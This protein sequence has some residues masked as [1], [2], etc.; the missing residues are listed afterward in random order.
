MYSF[1]KQV[2]KTIQHAALVA[3]A[4]LMLNGCGDFLE[5]KPRD[6]VTEDN[7]WNEKTDVDQMVLGC[8][9][10][11][12]SDAFI[13]RCIVWG[14]LRSDNIYPG[15]GVENDEKDLY[16]ALRENLLSTNRYCDWSSFYYVINKCNT[17]ITMAPKVSAIDPSYNDSQLRAT[18]AEMTA[19]RS[20]CYFYLIRAFDEVPFYREGIQEEDQV[21]YLPASKFDY[22]LNEIINDLESVK[23]D[24][25]VHYAQGNNDGD[26]QKFN[27][28]VNRITRTAINAMLT[29][30]Y[31][32]QG[33]YEK[34][35][36]CADAV[37]AQKRA[38]YEEEYSRQTGQLS[39]SNSSVPKLTDPAPNG[40]TAPLYAND[41]NNPSASA[42]AIF[43]GNGNS[44]E[45]IFELSYNWTGS[46]KDYV[47]STALGRLYG[48]AIPKGNNGAGFLTVNPRII[49]EITGTSMTYFY[50]VNDVRYYNWFIPTDDNYGEGYIRKGVAYTFNA[51]SGSSNKKIP[52]SSGFS[53]LGEQHRNWIFYR[54]TDVMLLEAEAYVM[55]TTDEGVA[56]GDADMLEDMK[57]AFDLVYTVCKRS[58]LSDFRLSSSSA[59]ATTR[60][61]LVDLIRKERN[62]ELMFEG[63]RWFDLVRQARRDGKP[64]FVRSA[65]PSKITGS[66]SSL[67][68]PSMD[69]LYWP[70]YKEELKKNDNLTQK[71]I[72]A[73]EAE[74]SF[75]SH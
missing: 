34:A 33:N 21:A 6:I 32:W 59:D 65:V 63:K 5:I 64:D 44:F 60:G 39:S 26:C 56:A 68:F 54:M 69:A 18:I 38:D 30:M 71:A 13:S 75:K 46:T 50:N 22:V 8:Y 36:A 24:A 61:L 1:M 2:Y 52:F 74:E 25:Y 55:K 3:C 17:V 11:M 29:D 19:L 47:E 20:L 45:S 10:A 43:G 67:A 7:F 53:V 40:L 37:M 4:G 31:L 28:N 49:N 16:E 42:N 66:G 51:S 70:Y 12:Q 14:E 57:Q 35:I 27:T 58:V 48:N 62:R 73:N 41:I 15:A 23:G 9:T 72:Y